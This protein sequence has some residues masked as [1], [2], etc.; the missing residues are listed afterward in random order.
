[1]AGTRAVVSVKATR[2]GTGSSGVAR[3]IAESKRDQEREGKGSRP[4][5]NEKEE[6]LT[7]R[8]ANKLL[9]PDKDGPA[10]RDIIH[11]V[12]S[13]AKEEYER[14][15]S[16]EE[17]RMDAFRAATRETMK[18][19][20]K[21]LKVE[22]LHWVAGIH[23]NTDQPHVHIAI[24]RDAVS[25]ET[26]KVTRIVHIPRELL[27]H[28][29]REKDGTARFVQGRM[30]ERF[31]HEVSAHQEHAADRA[32]EAERRQEEERAREEARVYKDRYVLGRAMVARG[33]VERL[34][35]SLEN[36]RE[37]GDKRRFR[38]HDDS[39]GRSRWISEFDIRR[40]ADA[41]ASRQV[42]EEKILNREERRE[43]RQDRY[44]TDV[45]K[46]GHGISNHQAI[47]D[48][49]IK[50]LEED[51]REAKQTYS[52]LR[53][54]ALTVKRTHEQDG[55]PLPIP[56]LNPR[57]I[58]TLESQAISARKPDRLLS[59]DRIRHALAEE[60]GGGART[61]KEAARL[62]GQLVVT[63]T[64]ERVRLKR[65]EDFERSR[66]Q[67]RFDIDGRKWSLTEVERR[68]KEQEGRLTL[69]GRKQDM[70]QRRRH[71]TLGER[72]QVI[73]LGR[74]A[75]LLP[76]GRRQAAAEIVRLAEIR[77][78]VEENLATRRET[79]KSELT[80]TSRMADT[81]QQ[82][83][84]REAEARRGREQSVPQPA[85]SRSELNRFEA[86][87]QLLK[88]SDLLQDFQ[89]YEA[90]HLD[91]LP[92][93]KQPSDEERA[94]RAV[95]REIVAEVAVLESESRLREFDERREFMP[96]IVGEGTDREHTTSLYEFREPQSAALRFAARALE[97]DEHREAREEVAEAVEEQHALILN[98]YE[99]SRSCFEVARGAADS[100]R[101]EFRAAG[102]ENPE[103]V[104]TRKE[105]NVLELFAE[106]QLDRAVFTQ[107]DR[108]IAT[109]EQEMRVV[110]AQQEDRVKA[111][112]D[113]VRDDRGIL[114]RSAGGTDIHQQQEQAAEADRQQDLTIEHEA[115][116]VED[117]SLLH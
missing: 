116:Q 11:L 45:T 41:R 16:T 99:Q 110:E 94:G 9:S 27:P 21:V 29:E 105:I 48:K 70:R 35:S 64:D 30:A 74:L 49:T 38:I 66:H 18:D 19:V 82:V 78:R 46:H 20:E 43:T 1:M 33:E 97:S 112:K 6:R 98:D 75:N 51:L 12:I 95:A 81:I 53:H 102:M 37:H 5:F 57:E 83:W 56:I 22:E 17:E 68:T 55:K 69:L 36:A 52:G 40:R 71:G 100:V 79:L 10:Q 86:N 96:V 115:V 103:P 60:R 23:R 104:F 4:L 7:Y 59:L 91:K 106:R 26:S 107:Y 39:K 108:I 42:Q 117:L 89:K 8:G 58:F 13:P 72:V 111:E 50:K 90:D 92:L 63:R 109:A 113:E 85:F 15:G 14:L 3:Y 24:G 61:D 31:L 73:L 28:N 65:L 80:E 101:E 62:R 84:T 114:E 77:A 54:A 32:Q 47:L 87:A 76:S 34:T 25:S 2:G 44:E 88:D 67:T 93:G